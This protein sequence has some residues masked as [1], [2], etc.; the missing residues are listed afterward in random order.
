MKKFLI[1]AMMV[2][3]CSTMQSKIGAENNQK[4]QCVSAMTLTI[5]ATCSNEKACIKKKLEKNY[6]AI[7][8]KCNLTSVQELISL[9]DNIQFMKNLSE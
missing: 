7:S 6:R 3:S 1:I 9:Y 5:G 2:A 8:N 4:V